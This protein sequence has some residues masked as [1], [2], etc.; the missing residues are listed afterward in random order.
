M[1]FS[2]GSNAIHSGP[3]WLLEESFIL[4]PCLKDT[5]VLPYKK[6]VK[7]LAGALKS[8]K[9]SVNDKEFSITIWNGL[10]LSF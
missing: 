1:L 7:Q 4:F 6:Q 10:P 8:M 9:V 3:R 2:M 5:K